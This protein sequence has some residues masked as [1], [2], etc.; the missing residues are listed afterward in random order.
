MD[1]K[2]Y[3]TPRE[4]EDYVE[5]RDNLT[6]MQ[7]IPNS[8]MTD[9]IWCKWRDCHQVVDDTHSKYWYH[10][11]ELLQRYDDSLLRVVA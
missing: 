9:E 10:V 4:W 7:S 8:D 3:I 11:E 6:K 2:E 5:A 1:N